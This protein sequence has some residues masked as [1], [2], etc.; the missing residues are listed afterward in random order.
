MTIF[1]RKSQALALLMLTASFGAGTL[2]ASTAKV[3]RPMAHDFK[4]EPF[5]TGSLATPKKKDP[6]QQALDDMIQSLCDAFYKSILER[7]GDIVRVQK[8]YAA[9]AG[10]VGSF[11]RVAPE[12]APRTQPRKMNF[13]P[14]VVL[15]Q[16]L[17]SVSQS[18]SRAPAAP[19]FAPPPPP[20]PPV[21]AQRGPLVIRRGQAP[22]PH[23]QAANAARNSVI[24]MG[25]LM[26]RAAAMSARRGGGDVVIPPRQNGPNPFQA[27]QLRSRTPQTP[28]QVHDTSTNEL[29]TVFAAMNRNRAS[30]PVP[31]QAATQPSFVGMA[32]SAVRALMQ[33]QN[34]ANPAPRRN[35]RARPAVTIPSATQPATIAAPAVAAQA[36]VQVQPNAPVTPVAAQPLAQTGPVPVTPSVAQGAT[37]PPPPPPYIARLSA[38]LGAADPGNQD[39][40]LRIA[41]S[42]QRAPLLS[43]LSQGNLMAGL[44]RTSSQQTITPTPVTP[45]P[46]AS[47]SL[48]QLFVSLLAGNAS[49]QQTPTARPVIDLDAVRREQEAREAENAQRQAAARARAEQQHLER[50]AREEAE[51]QERAEQTRRAQANASRQ[52]ALAMAQEPDENAPSGRA[53][54]ASITSFNLSNLRSIAAHPVAPV[55]PPPPS[56]L[57]AERLEQARTQSHLQATLVGRRAA[58]AIDSDDEDDGDDDFDW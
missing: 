52:Q 51:R 10:S 33:Q 7:S 15:Q 9:G 37:P 8:G 30:A 21:F 42:A 19:S 35:F 40:A 45:A 26:N 22:N 31:G 16:L 38:V 46:Q 50:I 18:P 2:E 24:N 44:R 29:A 5:K 28:M 47:Q 23:L 55:A 3:A 6:Q 1:N 43:Q 11:G 25:D 17:D 56:Q 32:P 58:M 34:A 41:Q 53:V 36:Q 12:F 20:P 49:T 13:D 4:V 54:L 14:L 39:A 48:G 27:V 57:D